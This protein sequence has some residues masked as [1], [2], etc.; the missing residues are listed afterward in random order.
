MFAK[1]V[2]VS[3][4]TLASGQLLAAECKVTVDSTD[5]MSFNTKAIEI[6]K[7]CKQF[8]VELTHSG[9]LPKNVMGHNWVLTTEANMQPVATDGMAAGIDKDYLKA[10]DERIIAHTKI[11][12]AGEKDSVTFDVS[13]LKAD[14]KY[15]FFCSFPGHISMMKGAVVLK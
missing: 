7:S 15:S 1:L 8:T 13:K 11:I 3:L 14:E 9:N 6:D 10:G 4:L 12:G 2:A 5:Q